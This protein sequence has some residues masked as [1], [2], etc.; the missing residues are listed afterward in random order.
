LLFFWQVNNRNSLERGSRSG[1]VFPILLICIAVLLAAVVVTRNTGEANIAKTCAS[2]AADAG[3]LTAASCMAAAFNRTVYRNWDSDSKEAPVGAG[4]GGV[5]LGRPPA[6]VSGYFD[7]Y[8]YKEMRK[9]F[10]DMNVQFEQLYQKSKEYLDDASKL[11]NDAIAN[12]NDAKAIIEGL[13]PLECHIG[14]A[15]PACGEWWNQLTT[16]AK[17]LFEDAADAIRSAAFNVGAF[18]ALAAYKGNGMGCVPGVN[19]QGQ[20]RP[21]CEGELTTG[22]T[23]WFRQNQLGHACQAFGYLNEARRQ[24]LLTAQK[25]AINNSCYSDK[26]T[27]SQRDDFNFWMG[28]EADGDGFNSGGGATVSYAPPGG[29]CSI[30]VT[31]LIPTTDKY[32]MRKS[33]WGFPKDR[34]DRVRKSIPFDCNCDDGDAILLITQEFRIDPFDYKASRNLVDDLLE[35]EKF[36]RKL[37]K[38]CDT[39]VFQW[40]VPGSQ[41]CCC[42]CGGSNLCGSCT[43]CGECCKWDNTGLICQ[44]ESHADCNY[45]DY[46]TEAERQRQ[47]LLSNINCFLPQLTKIVTAGG[48]NVSIPVLKDW[49]SQVW[50]NVWNTITFFGAKDCDSITIS[51]NAHDNIYFPGWMVHNIQDAT[52]S[53]ET[54]QTDCLAVSSCGATSQSKSKFCGG[55]WPCGGKGKLL[56][57]FQDIFDPEIT[58]TPK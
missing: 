13:P 38:R 39:I 29:G 24:G 19:A 47:C 46:Y 44:K 43:D 9:Y 21:W 26:L 2:N 15:G 35:I 27:D 20:P 52:L 8:Y 34:G 32:T 5:Y 14:S 58:E 3:S 53:D 36:L 4:H 12:I 56:G 49:N 30:D 41:C 55:G 17:P 51:P 16:D 31:L 48:T 25:M 23:Y 57:A 45:V 1:Q 37:A 22:L 7:Y 18:N 42:S 28:G 10:E 33:N 40:A 54:W 50:F 6:T 11:I